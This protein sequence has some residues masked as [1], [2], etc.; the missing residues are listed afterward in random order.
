MIVPKHD[1]PRLTALTLHVTNDSGPDTFNGVVISTVVEVCVVFDL[2]SIVYISLSSLSSSS[3]SSVSWKT[4][5]EQASS[6]SSSSSV[7][8]AV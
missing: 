7:V 3:S 2:F 1:P 5:V 4:L 8:V 6:S